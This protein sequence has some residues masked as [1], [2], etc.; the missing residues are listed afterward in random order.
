MKLISSLYSNANS[1]G[2]GDNTLP[3][4]EYAVEEVVQSKG[5]YLRKG[6]EG[7]ESK[8]ERNEKR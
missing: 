4:I 5:S 2:S 6:K 1:C 3:A 7:R 8:V